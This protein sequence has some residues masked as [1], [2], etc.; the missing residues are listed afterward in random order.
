MSCLKLVV[1]SEFLPEPILALSDLA[2][3]AK[4]LTLEPD[5]NVFLW[6]LPDWPKSD[7]P[8]PLTLDVAMNFSSS[9]LAGKALFIFTNYRESVLG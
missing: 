9:R 6:I 3:S 8:L 2:R 4:P 7:P 1:E 5:A